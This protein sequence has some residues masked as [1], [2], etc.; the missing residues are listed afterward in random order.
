MSARAAS[1]L[2]LVVSSLAWAQQDEGFIPYGED[3]PAEERRPRTRRKRA[4]LPPAPATSDEHPLRTD[5]SSAPDDLDLDAYSDQ[6]ADPVER[7][8]ANAAVKEDIWLSRT[9]DPYAGLAFELLGGAMLL[10][11]AH[12]AGVDPRPAA[13]LRATWEFGRVTGDEAWAERLFADLRWS[14][15]GSGGGTVRVSGESQYHHFGL[16]PAIAWL[17]GGGRDYSVYVQA[18]GGLAYQF[19]SIR[20]GESETQLAG[21]KPLL[22][23][24]VG[25]RGSPRLGPEQSLRLSLRIELTRFRRGYMDDTFLGGSAGLAF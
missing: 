1:L 23:Y 13:G 10:E 8:R 21:V 22:Q 7:K 18:G 2:A 19:A 25:F 17:L 6:E 24:G 4:K 3:P 11:S 15:T 9:D 14:V 20:D 5:E 16:A 12:G